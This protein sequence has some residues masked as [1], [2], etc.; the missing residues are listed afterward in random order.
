MKLDIFQVV[1]TLS[2][3]AESKN[4]PKSEKITEAA[5]KIVVTDDLI[6]NIPHFSADEMEE[7]SSYLNLIKKT[8]PT[9]F[10]KMNNWD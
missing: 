1:N 3:K 7:R 9:L 4:E 8:D 10:K 6:Q 2:E 5:K